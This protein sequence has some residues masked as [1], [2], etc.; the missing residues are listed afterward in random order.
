MIAPKFSARRFFDDVAR[1]D[2]TAFQYIGELCRYLVATPTHIREKRTK[3]RLALG[4]GLSAPVWSAFAQRFP[5]VR[6]LEFYASTE[7]NVWLYNVESRIGALGR[8]PP[9]VAA[10]APMCFQ[11]A[12]KVRL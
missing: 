5:A 12:L 6:V 4:N 1:W 2:C 7:G 3:L 9:F 8:L 11:K 10:K